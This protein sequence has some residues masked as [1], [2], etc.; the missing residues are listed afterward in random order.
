MPNP[1]VR[2]STA[3]GHFTVPLASALR[4]GMTVLDDHDALDANGRPRPPK[5][6]A[7]M[8]AVTESNPDPEADV[9]VDLEETENEY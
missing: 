7:D 6:R 2:V 5:L 9:S 3:R 4:G 8:G 1:F